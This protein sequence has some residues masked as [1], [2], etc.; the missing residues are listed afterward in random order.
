MCSCV[1]WKYENHDIAIAMSSSCADPVLG[2][3]ILQGWLKGFKYAT[4][5]AGSIY[6]FNSVS[7]PLLG[8]FKYLKSVS[9]HW[10]GAIKSLILTTNER[11][12]WWC[13][14]VLQ[15][16]GHSLLYRVILFIRHWNGGCCGHDLRVMRSQRQR[17]CMCSQ[18]WAQINFR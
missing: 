3:G 7:L 1:I 6:M 2:C 18:D 11:V 12:G 9:L 15:T 14:M 17:A 13:K 5:L 4:A 16:H 10:L 8:I